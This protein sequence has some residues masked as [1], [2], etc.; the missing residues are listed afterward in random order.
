MA[1]T[2]IREGSMNARIRRLFSTMLVIVLIASGLSRAGMNT[3]TLKVNVVDQLTAHTRA[4]PGVPS[5]ATR[6]S[7][8]VSVQ[9]RDGRAGILVPAGVASAACYDL[10]G[11]TVW[12]FTRANAQSQRHITVDGLRTNNCYMVLFR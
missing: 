6:T 9:A 11:K 8:V 3:A 4:A 7:K 5:A 2:E 10:T 1:E 12:V